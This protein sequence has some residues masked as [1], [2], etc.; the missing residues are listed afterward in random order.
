MPKKTKKTKE[1]V[2]KPPKKKK[3][4]KKLYFDMD[5]QDAIVRYNTL[6]P[7]ENQTERNKIFQ[8]EMPISFLC[9]W[10]WKA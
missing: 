6:D 9:L 10:A 7:V 4:K 1:V 8:E 3:A 5:V 2:P